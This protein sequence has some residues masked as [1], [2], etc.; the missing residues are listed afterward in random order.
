MSRPRAP[1]TE[2]EPAAP[3]PALPGSPAES[4]QVALDTQ[5]FVQLDQTN[6][7]RKKN[8]LRRHP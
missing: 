1:F 4:V 3:A 7:S 6:T 8:I 2:G 5:R